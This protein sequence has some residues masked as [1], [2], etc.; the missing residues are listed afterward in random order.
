MSRTV[1]ALRPGES[2]AAGFLRLLPRVTGTLA[3]RLSAA[4]AIGQLRGHDFGAPRHVHRRATFV[5]R[6][7]GQTLIVP[8]ESYVSAPSMQGRAAS[9]DCA[10]QAR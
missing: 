2:F 6:T 8:Y 4:R 7:C 3:A 10:S 5:C 1:G 9:S